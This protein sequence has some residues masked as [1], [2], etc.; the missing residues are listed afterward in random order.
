MHNSSQ[1]NSLGIKQLY[2][3]S[4][5]AGPRNEF[6]KISTLFRALLK[7][8]NKYLNKQGTYHVH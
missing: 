5:F 3:L 1:K 8:T 2:V 4:H 7:E 6:S